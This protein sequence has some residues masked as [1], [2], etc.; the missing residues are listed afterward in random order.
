MLGRVEVD[1]KKEGGS[2]EAF[3]DPN[4]RNLFAEVSRKVSGIV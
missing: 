4:K 2:E 1:E 3:E